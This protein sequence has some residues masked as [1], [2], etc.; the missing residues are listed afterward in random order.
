MVGCILT[1]HGPCPQGAQGVSP[2]IAQGRAGDGWD[3]GGPRCCGGGR[4]VRKTLGEGDIRIRLKKE[5]R[6][7]SRG[8]KEHQQ[9]HRVE[10]PEPFFRWINQ[11]GISSWKAPEEGQG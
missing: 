11:Y 10:K 9:R 3:Q 4:G 6:R 8:R 7:H 5:A 2:V 1:G